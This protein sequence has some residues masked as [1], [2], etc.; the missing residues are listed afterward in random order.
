MPIDRREMLAV[1]GSS[2]AFAPGLGGQ[3]PPPGAKPFGSGYFGEW[4]E[5][6]FGL[7]AFRYTCDQT[8]DPKARTAVTPG[9]LAPTEHVHQVGNGRVVAIASNFGH[10]QVRQD[11]GSPK[12][13]NGWSPERSQFS[14]GFGY[15]TDGRETLTTFYRGGEPAF[16]RIFGMGYFRKRV[17]SGSYLA[18]QV[19][20][21]PLGDDPVVLSQV[22]ITNH[23]KSAAR[24]RWVEY[25]GCH[26]Y[27]FSFRSFAESF[28]MS[29]PVVLRHQF[30]DRFEHHVGRA[31]ENAGLIESKRFPGRAP[32]EEAQWTRTKA[33]LAKGTN[34]FLGPVDESV[35]EASFDD[36]NPPPT[37][38]VALDA[39]PDGF[40]TDAKAFFGTG[41]AANPAGMAVPLGNTAA[42][43]TPGDA[44]LL[45]R[46][47]DLQPGEERTL[48]FLYGY[49]PSGFTLDGLLRKYR[50]AHAGVWRDSSLGWKAKRP[51]FSVSSEPWVAREC[52]WNHYYLRSGIT[53]DSFFGEHIL[54]QGSIYQYVMGFQGAARD[55]LQHALPFLYSEPAVLREVLRY[56]LKEVRPDGSIPY[57]I[58]GCGSVM[59]AASDNSSDM[60]LWLLWTASE[61]VLATRDRAFLDAPIPVWPGRS[62]ASQATVRSLLDRAYRHLVEQVGRG[63]HGLMRMLEDDW[64]DALVTGWAQRAHK[65]CVEQGESVLNSAMAAYVFDY[66]ARLLAYAGADPKAAAAA[67]HEAELHRQAVRG[68]WTGSWFRRAWLGPALGWLGQDSLWL[69]PQPWAILGGAVSEEQTHAL[70]RALDEKLRRPSRI[71][72]MQMMDASPDAG[73]APMFDPGT[74]VNG[75][76][77]PSL[78]QTLIWALARSDGR[79]AWEEWKK[80][81]LAWHADAY[82]DIWYGV[83]SGPDTYNAANSKR[84]GETVSSP[85]L[86]WTDFPVMNMHSHAC[87]LY[88]IGKLLGLEFQEDGFSLA[89]SLPLESYRFDTPLVGVVKTKNG[90]EGWYAP[91]APGAWTVR[92]SLPEKQL[93]N[94]ELNGKRVSPADGR[95]VE[96][97]GESGNGKPLRW[98][99]R[100]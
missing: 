20:A 23:G 68:Q 47:F 60:P 6:E 22:T 11:E 40:G 90:Y 3:T 54:S 55:P 93:R 35:P 28:P 37:F 85:F 83:W 99:A 95:T 44:L 66:Y 77:W 74:S 98:S 96:L 10:V 7:P 38:L 80:N 16:E 92:L 58:A 43:A 63:E 2:F 36:L 76:V 48:Y 9:I 72:A 67:R 84:P 94:F 1:L 100:G 13:L 24:L 19:I 49:L 42:G 71:G 29:S 51:Q 75:G 89:P 91:S 26:V 53:Y 39:P 41:G 82:P 4:M 59:P 5:D 8:T 64:N 86:H 70:V 31:P 69:E 87:T 17:R 18:D 65:E 12:F 81:T 78:N 27:Q 56:T 52:A 14:G 34:V 21:T 30:A 50:G 97:R 73:K 88:A 33:A 46:S 61:Y 25:W 45:E 79:M 57:G 62:G 32:E 15:L